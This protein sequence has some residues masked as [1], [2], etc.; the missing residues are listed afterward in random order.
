MSPQ[1]QIEGPYVVGLGAN[2]PK[3]HASCIVAA[4]EA[5]RQAEIPLLGTVLAGFGAGGMPMNRR[6]V[7][8]ANPENVGYGSGC[9][10]MLE[11]GIKSDFASSSCVRRSSLSKETPLPGPRPSI[12]ARGPQTHSEHLSRPT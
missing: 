12:E 6:A 4:M 11:G 7:P 9:A 1:A 10:M 8:N 2:N 5:L 3:G